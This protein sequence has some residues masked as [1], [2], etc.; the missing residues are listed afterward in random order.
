M[1]RPSPVSGRIALSPPRGI[2]C[3]REA[4]GGMRGT[5][6]THLDGYRRF[7]E[8]AASPASA[9]WSADAAASRGPRRSTPACSRRAS[10][11]GSRRTRRWPR[12]TWLADSIGMIDADRARGLT[13]AGAEPRRMAYAPRR[14]ALGVARRATRRRSPSR[15]GSNASSSGCSADRPVDLGFRAVDPLRAGE[16]AGPRRAR[17]T[18]APADPGRARA[19]SNDT[20]SSQSK[21]G[22]AVALRAGKRQQRSR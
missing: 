19:V 12:R 10:A 16:R 8:T 7:A 14:R 4:D 3:R 2:V 6:A 20:P 9:S 13:R 1:S 21:N 5:V 11:R 18:T 15:S 17:V 22:A